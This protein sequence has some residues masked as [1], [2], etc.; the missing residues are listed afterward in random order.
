MMSDDTEDRFDQIRAKGEEMIRR[1]GWM[2]QSVSPT[3]EQPGISYNYSIGL[4]AKGLPEILVIGL[5]LQIGHALVNDIVKLVMARKTMGSTFVGDIAHPKWPT[6][7]FLIEAQS[8]KAAEYALGAD[9][10]SDGVAKYIQIVWPDK[11]GRF[12]WNPD[13]TPEFRDAQPVLGAVA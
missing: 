8:D 2:V 13:A 7:F 6:H 11:E 5:P 10:R 3:Q 9:A 12:P 4:H 1:H